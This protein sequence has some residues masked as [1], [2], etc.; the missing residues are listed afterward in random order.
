MHQEYWGRE[1]IQ[2]KGAETEISGVNL[3]VMVKDKNTIWGSNEQL[4]WKNLDFK[5]TLNYFGQNLKV[6]HKLGPQGVSLNKPGLRQVFL[7]LLSSHLSPR[8]PV[9]HFDPRIFTQKIPALPFVIS[10][11]FLCATLV[12]NLWIMFEFRYTL[13]SQ[14]EKFNSG[15]NPIRSFL[16]RKNFWIFFVWK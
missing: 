1:K 4:V 13:H 7:L 2:E 15:T 10:L 5:K 14:T 9:Q 12:S 11:S 16:F 3:S 6:F 8:G